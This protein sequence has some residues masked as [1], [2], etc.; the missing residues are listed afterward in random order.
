MEGKNS[1]SRIRYQAKPHHCEILRKQINNSKMVDRLEINQNPSI[2]SRKAYNY[3]YKD[4]L[5]KQL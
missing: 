2:V 1:D 4:E 5:S 3:L